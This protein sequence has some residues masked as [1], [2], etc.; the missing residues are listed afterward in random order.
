MKASTFA[1][2]AALSAAALASR[3]Q[4]A[5]PTNASPEIVITSDHPMYVLRGRHYLISWK[6]GDSPLAAKVCADSMAFPGSCRI[7]GVGT[8]GLDWLVPLQQG[9]RSALDQDTGYRLPDPD[10]S[11]RRA[12]DSDQGVRHRHHVGRLGPGFD[13]AARRGVEVTRLRIANPTAAGGIFSCVIF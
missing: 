5:A 2:A 7:V 1:L 13:E 11:A 3:G 9:G 4:D 12:G 6:Y 8:N 10:R